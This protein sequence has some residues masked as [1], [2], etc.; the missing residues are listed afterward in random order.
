MFYI[1][2]ISRSHLSIAI[3]TG[4]Y[5]YG[6][7]KLEGESCAFCH[8][9][10][11]RFEVDAC[12]SIDRTNARIHFA[13]IQ[14][15]LKSFSQKLE[16]SGDRR[17]MRNKLVKE[18]RQGKSL[19]TK[20]A[21]VFIDI[22]STGA[23]NRSHCASPSNIDSFWHPVQLSHKHALPCSENVFPLSQP[24]FRQSLN[25]CVDLS[26]EQIDF[27]TTDESFATADARSWLASMENKALEPIASA[28]PHYQQAPT[29]NNVFPST[30]PSPS[31]TPHGVWISI[32]SPSF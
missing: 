15:S 20:D 11:R 2:H 24:L 22:R 14:D 17:Y 4:R 27:D 10:F 7:T 30:M 1:L 6:F 5:L 13:S 29:N 18:S 8:P 19:D 28:L 9:N 3:S 12:H 23:D 32:S 21:G 26:L 31:R 16:E 25:R